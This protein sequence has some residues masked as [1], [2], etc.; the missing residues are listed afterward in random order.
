M[1]VPNVLIYGCSDLIAP[2]IWIIIN[3]NVSTKQK[4]VF[5]TEYCTIISSIRSILCVWF[6][7]WKTLC[8]RV[9]IFKM[10]NELCS[11]HTRR[12]AFTNS[13]FVFSSSSLSYY[14]GTD[15]QIIFEYDLWCDRFVWKSLKGR[16][17]FVVFNAIVND[18][19][20][21]KTEYIFLTDVT[22]QLPISLRLREIST[23]SPQ[24]VRDLFQS[25][26]CG[27]NRSVIN[28]I[29]I[30][31]MSFQH[32]SILNT[33]FCNLIFSSAQRMEYSSVGLS[34]QSFSVY[35]FEHFS[36]WVFFQIFSS[37]PFFFNFHFQTIIF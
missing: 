18:S 17:H 29:R 1:L 30:L 28:F 10:G 34:F 3:W 20:D 24:A 6:S 37:I 8:H 32:Y 27:Y 4:T 16:K 7:S 35:L 15:R 11:S 13:L 9:K 23:L 36:F 22:T 21:W 2:T 25:F 26:K 33:R 5:T 12:V 19:K 14:H 31:L